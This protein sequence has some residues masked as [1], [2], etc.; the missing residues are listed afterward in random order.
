MAIVVTG[1]AGFIG[2]HLAHELRNHGQHVIGID[3]RPT[4]HRDDLVT[5]LLA[6]HATTEEALQTADA[7]YHLAGC[8]GIRDSRPDADQHRHRD[9]VLATERVLQLVPLSVPLVV[10][11]SSSVYGGSTA[12]RPCHEADPLRPRGGYATS[13]VKVEGLCARR[14]D[15]GGKVLVVRPFTVAGEGQ[16]TDMALSR[17]I[18]AVSDNQPVEVYGSLARCRD[19]TDVRHVAQALQLLMAAD[20]TGTVNIGTGQS[21]TLGEML[22]A[23]GQALDRAVTITLR[24]AAIEEVPATLA[25]VTRLIKLTELRPYTDLD[26]LIRRMVAYR[27]A[28]RPPDA[29]GG[30]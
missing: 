29:F 8:P 17:W 25:D 13:K 11:S 16:R 3:R 24:D 22:D 7:V 1:A 15:S 5:D 19:I 20:A 10:T 23:I 18:T 2:R 14:H 28:S 30:N 4:E 9:N 12:G 27:E 6:D 26:S 21:H